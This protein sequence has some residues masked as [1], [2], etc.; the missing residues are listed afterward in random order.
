MGTATAAPTQDN[1][2]AT[3][4]YILTW[5][6]GL[7]VLLIADKTD[8]NTRWHA[9]QAIG[10]GIV[11][12][13]VSWILSLLWGMMS[14]AGAGGG[15]MPGFGMFMGAGLLGSVWWLL[16]IVLVIVCATKAYKGE[17]FRI[18]VI[19]DIADKQA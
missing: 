11:A 3:I 2:K 19:A 1:T 13:V 14:F 9:I 10:L 16:V 5:L 18:P 12:T 4:A 8:K 15:L 17:R 6:T 7:I